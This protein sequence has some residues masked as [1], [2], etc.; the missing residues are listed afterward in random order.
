MLSPIERGSA[1]MAEL[2]T[3]RRTAKRTLA[4]RISS[5][6]RVNAEKGGEL[7]GIVPK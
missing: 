1:A 5:A 6:R 7:R 4:P 2:L 3:L